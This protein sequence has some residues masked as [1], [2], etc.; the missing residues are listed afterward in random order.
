[1]K[2][3]ILILLSFITFINVNA[4]TKLAKISF[5]NESYDFGKFKEEDGLQSY[6][7]TFTNT[8][9]EILNITD[10]HAS[11]GCTTPKWTKE[12]ITKGKT[13]EITVTYNPE[14]RP[15]PFQKTI[16]VKS[17]ADPSTQTLTIMGEVIPHEKSEK[18]L[19]PE[20]ILEL[21][22]SSKQ[23]SFSNMNTNLTKNE[24][25]Q[26]LNSSDKEITIEFYDVPEFIKV[27]AEP[28]VL[29]AKQKGKIICYYDAKKKNDIGFVIDKFKVKINGKTS[30]NNQMSASASIEEDFTK[31]TPTQIANAPIATLESKIY[32]FKTVK[33]GKS[34]KFNFTL[35]N[36]GKLDLKIRKIDSSCNCINLI[37]DKLTIKPNET[38][39]LVTTFNSKG[40]NGKILKRVTV[41]T[42]DPK[43]SKIS[44]IVKGNIE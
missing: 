37:A 30:I 34:L 44:L 41:F 36:T 32:D 6:T 1:M 7:F 23:F 40:Y 12:P 15:G 4:Q 19:F 20:E 26:V 28:K 31:L 9:T 18:E 38:I 5:V 22:L 3:I 11:C 14:N 10:V 17:N 42:N 39:N 27:T 25:I 29:A 33:A 43:N 2:N 16:T 24:A 13:G 8:G 35:K 21:R